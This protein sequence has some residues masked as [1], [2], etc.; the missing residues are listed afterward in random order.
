MKPK[1]RPTQSTF[2]EKTTVKPAPPKIRSNRPLRLGNVARRRRHQQASRRRVRRAGYKLFKFHCRS[3]KK[4]ANIHAH[5]K[6]RQCPFCGS[7]KIDAPKL[8]A[9]EPSELSP[10]KGLGLSMAMG[11]LSG[12]LSEVFPFILGLTPPERVGQHQK[13]KSGNPLP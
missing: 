7:E 6:P 13:F 1:K 8:K 10:L 3:C 2:E 11:L 5:S 4:R 12:L 9:W